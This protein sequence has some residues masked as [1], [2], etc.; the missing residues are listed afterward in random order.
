[1]KSV[2]FLLKM[3]GVVVAIPFLIP[4]AIV[5]HRLDRRRLRKAANQAHCGSCGAILGSA[6]LQ[7]ADEVWAEHVATLM[8]DRPGIRFRLIRHLR[9]TCVV[10][11][12]A[13]DF[14]ATRGVFVAMA[15][16]A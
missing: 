2:V 4:V 15:T 13:Y 5:L 9:A 8:R 6:S 3:M 16:V 14:D 7:R 1:M 12:A 10:C 11:G